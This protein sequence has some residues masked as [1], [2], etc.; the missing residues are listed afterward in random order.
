MFL[1]LL[2]GKL[3]QS[4]FRICKHVAYMQYRNTLY[5]EFKCIHN[6][7]LYFIQIYSKLQ[8]PSHFRKNILQNAD[9]PKI[10][11]NKNVKRRHMFMTGQY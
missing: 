7:L 6:L 4:H 5:M 3:K 8:L 11:N 1:N 10:L 2:Q 9:T